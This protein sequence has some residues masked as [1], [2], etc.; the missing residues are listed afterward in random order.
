MLDEQEPLFNE[1]RHFVECCQLG[2]NPRSGAGAGAAVTAIIETAQRSIDLGGV[3]VDVGMFAGD[4]PFADWLGS[5][6][7]F[8]PLVSQKHTHE[9]AGVASPV[10]LTVGQLARKHRAIVID[11]DQ[12]NRAFVADTLMSF[13]PGF[14][15]VTVAGVDEAAEWTDTFVPDLLVVSETLEQL[16]AT[17]FVTGLLAESA[18]RHCKVVSVGHIGNKDVGANRW[19]HASLNSEAGLSEWLETIRQ[20]LAR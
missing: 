13:E 14:D 5:P 11:P 12:S 20:V 9:G 15:V 8:S 7:E 1:C 18:S 16:S 10:A 4:T 6:D 3:P 19:R 17:D 2:K